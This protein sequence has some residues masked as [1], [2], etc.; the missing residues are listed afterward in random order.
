MLEFREADRQNGRRRQT[1]KQKRKR[2]RIETRKGSY[3]VHKEALI[4]KEHSGVSLHKTCFA[5]SLARPGAGHGSPLISPVRRFASPTER[6]PSSSSPLHISHRHF[7]PLK[8]S[9]SPEGIREPTRS[10]PEEEEE[11]E[12]EYKGTCL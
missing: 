7:S 12:E 5:S 8:G 1:E 2:K 9:L 11:E 10:G 6:P 4:T 3:S